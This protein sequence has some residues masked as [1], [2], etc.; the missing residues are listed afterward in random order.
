[1]KTAHTLN[2]VGVERDKIV[3]LPN[4]ITPGKD[5]GKA[6]EAAFLL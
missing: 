3:F 6:L 1:M 5:V 4:R 2:K